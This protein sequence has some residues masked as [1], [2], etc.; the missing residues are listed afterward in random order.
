MLT[1]EAVF[2]FSNINGFVTSLTGSDC[3]KDFRLLSNAA[4]LTP[5]YP[6]IPKSVNPRKPVK[7]NASP[8]ADT[9]APGRFPSL[10]FL[11]VFS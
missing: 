5:L 11:A 2:G 8:A 10:N 1:F 4:S 9:K 3:K 7:S 6:L